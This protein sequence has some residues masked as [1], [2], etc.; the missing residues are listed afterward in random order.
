MVLRKITESISI[1]TDSCNVYLIKDG[2]STLLIDFGRGDILRY[3][4]ETGVDKIDWILHTHHHREQCQGDRFANDMGIPIAVPKEEALLFNKVEQYWNELFT[5]KWD[6]NGAPFV[7][8]LISSIKTD[9]ELEDGDTFTCGNLVI[10]VI[11]TPG[12]TT[13]SLTFLLEVDGLKIAFIGD[14]FMEDGKIINF[15]DSE[16]D[17]GYCGGLKALSES[18][19]KLALQNPDILLPS[20]GEPIYNGRE[21]CYRFADKLTTL[22]EQYYLRDY[23]T[24]DNFENPSNNEPSI[25][26]EADFVSPHI[27]RWKDNFGNM[28]L[29]LGRNNTAMLVDAGI[30]H[31]EDS[32]KKREEFLA[33]RM[34]KLLEQYKIQKIEAVILSHYHGD[35]LDILYFIQ[36]KYGTKLWCYE[37]MVDV[38]EHPEN[39][40]LTCL[41]PW[42]GIPGEFKVDRVLHD[43]ES[44]EWGGY[45]LDIFHLPGQ[46]WHAMGMS[47][48]IDGIKNVFIGDNLFYSSKGSGHDA[49]VMRNRGI[50]EE[51]F[52]KCAEILK[53][54]KPQR[55]LCG[56]SIMINQPEEQL[57][58]FYK[59]AY[60]FRTALQSFSPY[61]EYE[62]IIDP[63]WVEI[64]PYRTIV[65]NA[66]KIKKTIKIC[67][68]HGY[69]T[70]MKGKLCCPDGWKVKPESFEIVIEARSI[71]LFD[72]YVCIPEQISSGRYP[73]TVDI[74]DGKEDCGQL[75]DGVV[76]IKR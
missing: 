52:I 28:Y 19:R 16:W 20:H 34:D 9:M 66:Q 1:Y 69:R 33:E 3:K 7:R 10:R 65:K 75:F 41:L 53:S 59:W 5:K 55:L 6:C 38:I 40:N 42:Y 43:G 54:L 35:H 49:F 76:E 60:D 57:K 45:K 22:I 51:G 21:Q 26:P 48:V 27:I 15:Y 2:N 47:A 14:L 62:W 32:Q 36:E 11:G 67:N 73:L 13:G 24:T 30:I 61:E 63:Y 12:H 72:V 70:V 64:F 58:R 17:Y 25:I 44:L 37:N 50:L 39:Y 71:V 68:H 31:Y 56:H 74:K 46:T 23:D 18:C 4:G 29:I 8:P